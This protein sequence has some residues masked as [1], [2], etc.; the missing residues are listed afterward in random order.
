[1]LLGYFSVSRN[2]WYSL[3]HLTSEVSTVL[4]QDEA[5]PI[6]QCRTIPHICQGTTGGTCEKK[7]C[8]VEKMTISM[9]T[10]KEP[11]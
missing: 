7:I 2:L 1:M 4:T 8:H 5:L 3:V 11:S 9:N 10:L 6:R